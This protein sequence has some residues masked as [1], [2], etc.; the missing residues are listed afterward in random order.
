MR[1]Q[2]KSAD[3]RASGSKREKSKPSPSRD[4]PADKRALLE[5]FD[6]FSGV[7]NALRAIAE[8][9]QEWAGIPMPIDGERLV[10]EPRYPN[11]EALSQIGAPEEKEEDVKMRNTFWSDRLRSEILIWEED[12]KIVWGKGSP[13]H[14]FGIDIR[15]LGCSEAWGIEQESNAI[16]L[17]ASIVSPRQMKAYL[18]T[19]MFLETSKRSGMTYMF[20]RLKP[21]VVIDSR[22]H[23]AE[24]RILACLCMHPI[25]YYQGSWAGAMCPSDDVVAHLTFMR[26]DERRYW[27]RCNQIHPSRP[28][29]GL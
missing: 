4:L 12:G 18:L 8:M 5:R 29:A 10:I 21:T 23:K 25:G 2:N 11:A 15:T 3:G 14:H 16:N 17:L 22:P 6:N 24:P 19:G 27:S 28:E 7:R 9:R 20:R 26:G 1:Q 13:A